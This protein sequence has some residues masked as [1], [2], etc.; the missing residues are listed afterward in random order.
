MNNV[1]LANYSIEYQED[2]VY[3]TVFPS[4]NGL[5]KEDETEILDILKRKSIIGIDTNAVYNAMYISPGNK[6]KIAPTQKEKM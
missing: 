5:T 3:L 4:E 2:G 6:A 1:K